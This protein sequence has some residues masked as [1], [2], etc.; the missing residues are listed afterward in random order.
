MI[1]SHRISQLL[2]SLL[3]LFGIKATWLALLLS[4]LLAA[5]LVCCGA[6]N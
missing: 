4:V 1:A 3:C 5:S 6:D 2:Q